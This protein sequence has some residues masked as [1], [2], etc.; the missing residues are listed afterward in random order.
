[1]KKTKLSQTYLRERYLGKPLEKNDQEEFN[2]SLCGAL[3]KANISLKKLKNPSFSAFD[4]LAYFRL[5][6]LIAAYFKGFDCIF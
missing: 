2:I 3:V 1:L 6:V 5:I 4:I